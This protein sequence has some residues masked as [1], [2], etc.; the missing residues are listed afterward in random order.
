ME[1][2][3]FVN[4]HDLT[5]KSKDD[6]E[7]RVYL[8]PIES[9]RNL[10]LYKNEGVKIRARC[11]GKMLVFTMS[12]G[13]G[14]TGPNRGMEAGPSGSSGLTTRSKK[15]EYRVNLD[16]PVKAVQ[17]QLQR[18]LEVQI[19]MSK[20]FKAKAKAE[21]EINGDHVLQ[22]SI[23]RDYVVELQ[24]TNPNT[25]I[26]IVVERNI[27]PSLPIRVFK[28][29]YV[30]LGALKLGFKAC[31]RDL[32]GLDG[33]FMKGPL[34][35]QVLVAVGLDSNNGIY[36]LAYALVEAESKSSWCWFLQCLGD[37]IDRHPNS[38]FTFI[39]GRQKGIIPAIKTV[40][41]SA[42]HRYC[43]R[44][45]HDNIKKGWYEQ[46]YKDLLWIGEFATNVRDFE[47]C[48][49]EF[50]MMNPKAH[51]CRAKSELLLNNIC[52]VF[53]GKIVGGRNKLLITLLKY[54]KEYCMKIILNVQGVI[55]KCIVPLTPT[56]TRIM[57]SIKKEAHLMKEQWNGVNKYQVSGSLVDQCVVDVLTRIFFNMGRNNAKASGSASSQAQQ[58]EPVVGQDGS[59]GL[60]VG[61]VIGL[62]AVA[63]KGGAGGL[64]GV[65]VASQVSETKNSDRREMGD[66][67][68][69][70]SSAACGASEWSFM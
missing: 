31:R 49:L 30:C 43:L 58:T 32:L 4:Y 47:K 17:D 37:D 70:Q 60:S 66:G 61:V 16:I 26:K 36:P 19:S 1:L 22:Y 11:D 67:V 34:P 14:P 20:A 8:H 64:G 2:I 68:P 45:I 57:E 13:T 35:S 10:K 41:P 27:D 69:T 40:Y 39:S 23:L 53:N 54:I 55:D 46:A 56:A 3:T 59:G 42:K 51:E 7:D 6:A 63:G 5:V 21:K 18:E 50:K 9:R 33:A 65:G 52:E 28:R 29:I 62:S 15:K 25:T 38:N 44:L 24:S 12:Q 48:M